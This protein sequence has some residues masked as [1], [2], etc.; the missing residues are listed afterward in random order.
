VAGDAPTLE[1]ERTAARAVTFVLI[2]HEDEGRRRFV[3]PAG[4]TL[5]VGRDD[6]ADLQLRKPTVSRRH[7]RITARGALSVEDMDSTNGTWVGE[8]RLSRGEVTEVPVGAVLRLGTLVMT[9]EGELSAAAPAEGREAEPRAEASLGPHLSAAAVADRRMRELHER[10]RILARGR[11]SVLI[12]GETG[13]GKEVYAAAIHG[14]SSRRSGPFLRINCAALPFEMVESELF[15]H[16]RGAFTGAVAAKAGLLE[17]AHGGTV[18]L[19][20]VGD[21]PLPTQAKLLRVLE[22]G[23]VTRLGAVSPRALDIRILAATNR[24]LPGMIGQGLFRADLYYRLAAAE[25]WIPPLRERL[26]D[27]DVLLGH[28][29]EMSCVVLGTGPKVFGPAARAVLRSHSWPG[30][31]RE[32]KNVVERAVLFAPDPIIDA[33]HVSFVGTQSA[34]PA[35][36]V[37]PTAQLRLDGASVAG[38]RPARADYYQTLREREKAAI[39]AAL[40]MCRGN[41]TRAAERLNMPRRTLT[42]RLTEYGIRKPRRSS[43]GGRGLGE[44]GPSVSGGALL[45]A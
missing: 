32:L 28:F 33:C 8:R 7:A 18:L 5:V 14:H 29:V 19:D 39:L 3:I 38:I 34:P 31:V 20:E 41:Q 25:V 30:N 43:G 11:G 22:A 10:A 40:E 37:V 12:L 44:G 35:R 36:T 6:T 23:E 4:T 9:V 2:A 26:D 1:I 45:P 24:D 15:G 21:L 17:R 16:E 42:K 13:V 27:L